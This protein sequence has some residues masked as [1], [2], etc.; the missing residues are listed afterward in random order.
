VGDPE[1]EYFVTLLRE[2][3]ITIST[4]FGPP[5]HPPKPKGDATRSHRFALGVDGLEVGHRYRLE[6]SHGPKTYWWQYGTREQLLASPESRGGQLGPCCRSRRLGSR[7]N[8]SRPSSLKSR[9]ELG[10][11]PLSSSYPE[12]RLVWGQSSPRLSS[13]LIAFSMPRESGPDECITLVLRS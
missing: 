6:V 1:D 13:A 3:P 10:S 5:D 8:L 4:P 11:R 9:P 12:P 2:D 7:L